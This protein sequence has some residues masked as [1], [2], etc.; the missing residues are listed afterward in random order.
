MSSK[1][2]DSF[3]WVEK[4]RPQ[5]IKEV[6][7][8]KAT[9]AQF[10]KHINNGQIPNLLL[11]SS[12]PGTGKST[13]AKAI[14]ND[15]KADMMYINASSEG[16]ID[17]LRT[18]IQKFAACKSFHGGPKIVVLD[19]ADG[20]SPQ[21]QAALRAFIEEFHKSCRF[22]L[23]CNY[24]TKIIEP[25]HSRLQKIDFNIMDQKVQ[26]EMMP[27]IAKRLCLILEKAEK[28]EFKPET[29]IKLV[30]TYYPDI[31]KMLSL[32][33]Q[34]NDIHGCINNDIFSMSEVDSEFYDY[35]LNRNLTKAREYV[36]N[37][38]MNYDELYSLLFKNLIPKMEK[39]H[40]AQTIILLA[41]YQSRHCI[42]KELNF[43]ACLLEI[44]SVLSE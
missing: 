14:C 39:Q 5:S 21:F 16:G 4:Y 2:F 28:V 17:T 31:R 8:P 3:L 40:Q 29:I 44:M 41:D 35:V 38:N 24:E 20:L 27:K 37:K 32:C 26:E 22:I 1:K 34:F 6:I 18:R 36:I 33:Q 43:A 25:L 23:T 15:L 9:K 42:D 19:E 30:K 13:V 7:L 12:S 11:V 10:T